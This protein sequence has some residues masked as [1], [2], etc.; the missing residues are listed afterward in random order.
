[1]SPK[2]K[3]TKRRWLTPRITGSQDSSRGS[4]GSSSRNKTILVTTTATVL[5]SIMGYLS[6]NFLATRQQKELDNRLYIELI[7]GRE[8]AESDL[9][10]DMFTQIIKAFVDTSEGG[11]ESRLL[12]LELLAY[13]FH[14]SLNLKP[15]FVSLLEDIDV[16]RNRYND[17]CSAA[18]RSGG[19]GKLGDL[20]RSYGG[21]VHRDFVY[22]S[23]GS[24]E[25]EGERDS[26]AKGD[27]AI[28]RRPALDCDSAV[29]YRDWYRRLLRVASEIKDDQVSM[30]DMKGDVKTFEV[31]IV[32]PHAT[33]S[34]CGL[35]YGLGQ[36]GLAHDSALWTLSCDFGEGAENPTL[37][38][39]VYLIDDTLIQIDSLDAKRTFEIQVGVPED[40]TATELDIRVRVHTLSDKDRT[41][42]NTSKPPEDSTPKSRRFPKRSDGSAPSTNLLPKRFPA[43]WAPEKETTELSKGHFGLSL[44][45]FPLIDN[46][47]LPGDYRYAIV[48]NGIDS[49]NAD[50]PVVEMSLV[51][52][53]GKYSSLKD[54]RFYDDVIEQLSREN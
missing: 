38:C 5:I 10:K 1:M 40:P 9:R 28:Y 46:S 17:A 54:K 2:R 41:P 31:P 47:R 36:S 37:P 43:D 53:R 33:D 8:K 19:L 14:E 15:L 27:P 12:N 7:T 26:N 16:G 20:D 18:L 52:F 49:S 6:A 39:F 25:P 35:Y 3:L 51:Y 50:K 44:F 23:L 11:V 34:A 32:S 22:K 24:F 30:L 42:P 4:T 13:N 21:R 29:V 45:D 48:L